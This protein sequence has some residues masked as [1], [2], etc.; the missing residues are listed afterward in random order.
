MG[1]WA[2]LG[3]LAV[4]HPSPLKAQDPAREIYERMLA[5]YDPHLLREAED[6]GLYDRESLPVLR[7]MNP[8]FLR[9]D[10]NGDGEMDLAFWVRDGV[11]G[12]RGIAI[13][14]STLDTLYVFGAGRPGPPPEGVVPNQG[15]VDAWHLIPAGHTDSHQYGDIP[16]IGAVREAPFTFERDT[17]EFVFLGKS[18]FVFYW[19]N[20]RY[21]I[22]GTSD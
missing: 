11:S 2:G 3:V 5:A 18:A 4:T 8:F 20:G 16:E 22:F 21:W 17:L 9:G 15:R 19:A 7:E 6:K 12:E 13:L 10:L 14:H 1:V